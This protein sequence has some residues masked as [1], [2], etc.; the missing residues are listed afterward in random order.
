MYIL[1][2]FFRIGQKLNMSR[3]MTK[4]TKWH[5]APRGD[6]DQPE[7]PPIL[8]K[9][10]AD[11]MKKAWFLSY[12]LNAS[13]DVDQTGRM[14]RLIRVFGGRTCHFVVFVVRRLIY[15]LQFVG[16]SLFR[17]GSTFQTHYSSDLLYTVKP[18]I[19]AH[20]LFRDFV[21]WDVFAEI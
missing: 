9:V 17:T 12:P 15:C 21:I 14:P 1:I 3:L 4:P 7:H 10:F 6:S 16:I 2:T 11:R 20:S 5:S 19:F 8:I 13:E 18:F